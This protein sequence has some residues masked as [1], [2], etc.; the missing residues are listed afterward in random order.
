M[1]VADYN[2]YVFEYAA[3]DLGASGSPAPA[4]TID[5]SAY[6]S[7][8]YALAFDASGDLWVSA[9]DTSQILMFTPSQLAAGGVQSATVVLDSTG[10]GSI[11]GPGGIAFD[12]SGALWVGNYDND[13]VVKFASADLAASGSPTPSVILSATSASIYQPNGLAFDASGNLWVSNGGGTVVRFDAGQL[14]TTASP[15]PAATIAASSLGGTPTGL[16]F[17]ASGT[18]WVSDHTSGDLLAFKNP[19]ALTG[20]TSPSADVTI[21]SIGIVDY[22]LIA[23]DPPPANLPI[24][25]P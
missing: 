17:D 4:V 12:A 5:L 25:T 14:G 3:A 13:T 24:N 1:W 16:A 8:L 23:F 2:G 6:G 15:V 11:A 19:G 9:Y 18:L 20:S 22:P 7:A 10:G 21:S